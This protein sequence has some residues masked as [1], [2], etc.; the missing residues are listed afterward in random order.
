MQLI[1]VPI[2]ATSL[3]AGVA[4]TG[5]G[6]KQPVDPLTFDC[7]KWKDQ[8]TCTS[9]R[10]C[11]WV[12]NRGNPFVCAN[13]PAPATAGCASHQDQK[14]CSA[15]ESCAWANDACG[16]T[17]APGPGPAPAPKTCAAITS[18]PKD[19][20]DS[21]IDG[22]CHW[23]VFQWNVCTEDHAG[24]CK[25]GK[26]PPGPKYC[27]DIKNDSECNN[28]SIAG[29]CHWD[30]VTCQPGKAPEPPKTCSDITIDSKCNTSTIT[31]GC[32][33]DVTCKSGPPPKPAP[34]SC[35]EI[36]SQS[37]CT[38]STLPDGCHWDFD[39][40]MP[41][42]APKETCANIQTESD[43]KVSALPGGCH[44]DGA[45][46]KDGS[47]DEC[48][49]LD[50]SDC[51]VTDGCT[52]N[53]FTQNPTCESNTNFCEGRGTI[54]P[55]GLFLYAAHM[56]QEWTLVCAWD[57]ANKT[58]YAPDVQPARSCS[59]IVQTQGVCDKLSRCQWDSSDNSCTD[60]AAPEL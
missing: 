38:K 31:G 2:V 1:S 58:C 47:A 41:G 15:D 53:N 37:D 23:E 57:S 44:W 21:K 11:Y 14:S 50:E 30:Q 25:P 49:I 10:A 12:P 18:S 48:V 6:K 43:C 52:W 32:H 59:D 60:A 27:C 51:S 17:P 22:G 4:L 56:C 3:I 45:I 35:S 33:W 9:Y 46:C 55:E 8:T 24:E 29:G 36:A 20:N 7:S 28:S 42:A 16:N 34:K 19:C 13:K 40:C 5:C 54:G 26:A 39:V